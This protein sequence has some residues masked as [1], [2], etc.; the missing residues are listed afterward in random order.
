MNDIAIPG[1]GSPPWIE[2]LTAAL[3]PATRESYANGSRKWEAFAREHDATPL[4]ADP[5]AL[6]AF[7][8]H[9]AGA[10]A[11]VRPSTIRAAVV[12]AVRSHRDA[13]G[14]VHQSTG[15]TA[16]AVARIEAT[17]YRPRPRG[18]GMESPA[19]AK[20]RADLEIALIRTMRDCLARV[21][22]A[23]AFTWQQTERRPDGSRPRSHSGARR[24]MP[25]PRHTSPRPPSPHSTR[26]A[27]APQTPRRCSTRAQ[28]ASRPASRPP[29]RPPDWKGFQATDAGSG[30]RRTS[31]VRRVSRCLPSCRQ[32]AGD[33]RRRLPGT[34][35]AR[36]PSAAPWPGSTSRKAPSSD[37]RSAR[38]RAD[39]ESR[40]RNRS[41][42]MPNAAALRK[43][44]PR[45]RPGTLPLRSHRLRRAP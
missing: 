41:T 19:V 44:T 39:T 10:A 6:A 20:A 4:P 28:A 32:E 37:R 36:A 13:G 16:A 3:A 2:R 22:E 42:P 23:A 14:T 43:P 12:R 1:A 8:E 38:Y 33:R 18:R 24:R 17:A 9:L 15:I 40:P 31:P 25:T 29:R 5:E 34:P 35:P 26:S 7:V 21:S 45:P 27:T 30:W 11:G